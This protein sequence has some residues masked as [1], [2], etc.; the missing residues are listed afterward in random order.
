MVVP[1]QGLMLV[2]MTTG[3][4]VAMPQPQ[5]LPSCIPSTPT[6]P[7]PPPQ[8]E[9][10][11][12]DTV[13]VQRRSSGAETSLLAG[14]NE[15]SDDDDGIDETVVLQGIHKAAGSLRAPLASR[16]SSNDNAQC[17]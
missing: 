15:S 1:G 3:Q 8:Q 17:E 12:P 16:T 9:T 2:N 11:I 5:S 13:P 10:Y 7:P 14:D 6:Q 4:M